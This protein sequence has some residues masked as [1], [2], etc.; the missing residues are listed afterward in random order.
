M[1][2]YIRVTASLAGCTAAQEMLSSIIASRRGPC[3][4][5]R[6][7]HQMPK[8][9][10]HYS[11][12]LEGMKDISARAYHWPRTEAFRY[13]RHPVLARWE[14][15]SSRDRAWRQSSPLFSR[16][17]GTNHS[18]LPQDLHRLYGRNKLIHIWKSITSIL[19]CS[20]LSH[21]PGCSFFSELRPA[22]RI[23]S[24][25]NMFVAIT[26]LWDV[27]ALHLTKKW[28]LTSYA[29]CVSMCDIGPKSL[30]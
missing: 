2:W 19:F 9:H 8:A 24:T 10:N 28:L 25:D 20:L 21:G 3:L 23:S 5:S 6:S 1:H 15:D 13:V 29:T 11:P 22:R 4:E 26:A 17:Y 18:M 12:L 30:A 27:S 16:L 7:S 14:C